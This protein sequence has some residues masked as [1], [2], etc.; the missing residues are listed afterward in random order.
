MADLT[1]ASELARLVHDASTGPGR[2]PTG[3]EGVDVFR[4]DGVSPIR[5]GIYWPMVII[6][7]QGR[8]YARV[9]G[10]VYE[11]SP[12]SYLVTSVTIPVE[13]QVVEASPERPFLS[14]SVAV[15]PTLLGQLIVEAGLDTPLHDDPALGL[16]VSTVGH[17]LLDAAVRLFQCRDS[18]TDLRVLAPAYKREILYRVLLGDQGNLLR[19][20]LNPGG[21][22]NQ[23]VRAL[24]LIHEEFAGELNVAMLAREAHMSESA[25]YDA[26]REVT[27]FT[28][29]QYIKDIRLNLARS[30]LVWEGTSA[31]A[32]SRRVGYKSASQFSREFKRKFGRPPGEEQKWAEAAGEVQGLRPY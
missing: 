10:Q 7:A 11:Y 18:E 28:P 12:S 8:K 14:F 25:F 2:N 3:I 6:V 5:S 9:G 29:I 4:A 22:V 32:A 1:R 17:R 13:A 27:S 20:A 15:E 31:K 26:F 30:I 16:A 24:N 21:R 23:V 19:A